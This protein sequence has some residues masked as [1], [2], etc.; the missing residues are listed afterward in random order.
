MNGQDE[1]TRRLRAS[2]SVYAEREA[3]LITQ[4]FTSAHAREAA[5]IRRQGGEPLEYVLGWARFGAVRVAINAPG[6]I[7]RAR[8]VALVDA[9]DTNVAADRH[10]V[11]A[12]D[13]G[14][15]VG[16]IAA[17]LTDR[18]PDWEVHGCDIDAAAVAVARRNAETFGFTV[19]SGTWFEALPAALRGRL[20]VVVAHLPYVPSAAIAQLPRDFRDHEPRHTVD[21]GADGLDPLRQVCRAGPGWLA[22][23]G[24]FLT[25]VNRDQRKTAEAIAGNAGLG[26]QAIATASAPTAA[27]YDEDTLV[28]A[29]RPNVDPR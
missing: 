7:P 21:G 23:G 26:C 2:G 11:I 28:L 24:V 18:H 16:A 22:P 19:H 29:L 15:G 5:T 9:A 17:A 6:F 8:A 1:I 13:L 3:E 4:T 14:C 25:Q 12:L 27:A 20:D 10:R